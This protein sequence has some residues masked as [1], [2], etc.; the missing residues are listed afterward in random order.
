M[1]HSMNRCR[2][3]DNYLRGME[4]CKFCSFEWASD[5]PPTDDIDWDIL[6]INDDIEWGHFQLRDRLYYK[7]IECL[8]TDIWYDNNLALIIGARANGEQIAE[9]LN[10]HPEVVYDFSDNGLMIL[11]LYQEKCLRD[12]E[13]LERFYD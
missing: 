10:I 3:C 9:A 13:N 12:D 8:M 6:D 2:V 5:Y 11:N 4:Q 1:K 7:G